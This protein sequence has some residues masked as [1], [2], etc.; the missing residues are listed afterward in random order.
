MSESSDFYEILQ[1]HPAAHP[2]VIQSAYGRLAQI[3][4]PDEDPAAYSAARMAEIDRA[5]AVLNDP[6]QRVAYDRQRAGEGHGI[7]N[8]A[9]VPDVIRAKSFQLVNDDGQTRAELSLDW[10][11]ASKLVMHDQHGNTWLEMYEE[12]EG[13]ARVLLND[14]H[15]NL[16]LILG[17]GDD[18]VVLMM[19][20][21]NHGFNNRFEMQQDWNGFRFV[22][23][24]QGNP[25]HLEVRVRDDGTPSLVM[26]ERDGG[27]RFVIQQ[28]D[29]V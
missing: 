29:D 8:D 9:L 20:A 23:W 15:G 14:Y 6:Q 4:R 3:Y 19:L 21:E 5:Y 28:I 27:R 10:T 17:A 12:H 1:V 7:G 13:G 26:S 24:H 25:V 22:F 18:G 2:D 16:R 11:G